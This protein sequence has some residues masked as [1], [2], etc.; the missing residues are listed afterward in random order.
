MT[1]LRDELAW[2]VGKNTCMTITPAMILAMPTSVAG[3]R[4]WPY[5]NHLVSLRVE[6]PRL[7][8]VCGAFEPVRQTV[9]FSLFYAAD[10][11]YHRRTGHLCG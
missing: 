9:V 2:L 10:E 6:M 1:E 11:E 8:A 5:T 4:R 7:A 3:S